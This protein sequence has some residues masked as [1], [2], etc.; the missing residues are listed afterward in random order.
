[1]AKVCW[2]FVSLKTKQLILIFHLFNPEM[3]IACF[4][5]L[6]LAVCYEMLKYLREYIR[7]QQIQSDAM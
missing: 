3:L 5:T 6:I 1:M 2:H 7:G 4:L